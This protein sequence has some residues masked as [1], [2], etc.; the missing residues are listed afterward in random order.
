[1]FSNTAH[2]NNKL[3]PT[4]KYLKDMNFALDYALEN[5]KIMMKK[6]L[7]ILGYDH[8]INTLIRL[9]MVNENHNHAVVE[10]DNKVLHRKGATQADLGQIGIIPGSMKSG[11][12]VTEGLGNEEYLKSSSHGAGR[13]MSRKKAK[14][15]TTL[16]KFKQQM[17]G[18]VAKVENTTK[19][20][21]PHAYKNLHKIIEKQEGIVIKTIDYC[22]PLINV[23]G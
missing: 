3:K 15:S 23:K 2:N 21:A 14:E 22:K 11:V 1:L 7:S 9:Q 20:E 19:D 4:K 13:T 10:K 16:K 8:E 12:Y 18:I 5:R 17:R 6:V